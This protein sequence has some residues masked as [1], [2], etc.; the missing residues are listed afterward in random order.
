MSLRSK[1]SGYLDRF[2]GG[3]AF[4]ARVGV[5]AREASPR[6][7]RIHPR[8]AGMTHIYVEASFLCNLE[9]RMCPRLLEGHSEGLMP[10][11]RFHRLVPLM[12]HLEAVI[13]TGYGEPLLH[14]HLHEFVAVAR[15]CGS[16]PRLSTNG[17]ILSAEKA[18]RLLD[19]GL[20]NLQV[21]IDAG[22]K[23]TFE[24]IRVGGNW[25]RVLRNS[26]AF[27][28]MVRDRGL[29]VGS[30]W[31]FVVMRSNYRELP[32]AVR[33]AASCG[34]PLF[35]AK[36]IERNALEYENEQNMHAP[37]GSLLVDEAEF[38]A[39]LD[40]CRAIADANGMEFRLHPFHLGET[41][42]CLADPL[43]SF[44]LDWMG[45]IS[46]CCHLPVRNEQGHHPLHSFGNIDDEDVM[47]ILLGPRARQFFDNW[48]NRRIPFACRRCYQV[49]RL[50]DRHLYTHGD[51][52]P[53]ELAGR[54]TR[55]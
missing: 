41:G 39:L 48:R 35:V 22:T 7:S 47:G 52:W 36:F 51:D 5:A 40:E 23:G 53:E 3:R 10:L 30:G 14:P 42:A 24:H 32:L 4:K 19:A 21:S 9:C 33:H 49:T 6:G 34:F 26:E 46:P 16:L 44:F 18:A 25:E 8:L 1:V 2:E 50:P 54:V 43:R 37:D 28:S 29:A 38:Q 31:V 13:L 17:T 20:D 55:S 12:R 45:N 27:H 11:E 15:S